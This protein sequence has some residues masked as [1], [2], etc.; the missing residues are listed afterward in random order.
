[1][2]PCLFL[3]LTLS[4]CLSKADQSCRLLACWAMHEHATANRLL[5]Y[6][7]NNSGNNKSYSK[8]HKTCLIAVT[9][10]GRRQKYSLKTECDKVEV[11][12]VLNK[13]GKA[14]A[15]CLHLTRQLSQMYSDFLTR[16][17]CS[18]LGGGTK[19]EQHVGAEID[20]YFRRQELMASRTIS[21]TIQIP[22]GNAL[23]FSIKHFKRPVLNNLH[24]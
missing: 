18:Y 23:S 21:S 10:T 24:C 1:M 9:N 12:L 13:K 2:G 6:W 16:V 11:N 20:I 17:N 8:L 4:S 5:T 15:N 14:A 22:C 7:S 19:T 3:I